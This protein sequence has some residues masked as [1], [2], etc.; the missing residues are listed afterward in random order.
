MVISSASEPISRA[1]TV[2]TISSLA[3]FPHLFL[4]PRYSKKSGHG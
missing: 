3:F 1:R 2:S 4:C